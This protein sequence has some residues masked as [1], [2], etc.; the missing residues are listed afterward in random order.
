[1][2]PVTVPLSVPIVHEGQSLSSITFR[3]ATVKDLISA[4]EQDGELKQTISMLASSSGLSFDTFTQVC[5]KDLKTIMDSTSEL[6]GNGK[7]STT[8]EA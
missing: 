5:T 1:M 8:G 4:S 2:Q 3:P 6:L 7:A